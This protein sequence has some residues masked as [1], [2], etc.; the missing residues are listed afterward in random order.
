V[1][2]SKHERHGSWGKWGTS[3]LP[4]ED[5]IWGAG[6]YRADTPEETKRRV[7]PSHDEGYK[8]FAPFGFVRYADEQYPYLER[9]DFSSGIRGSG[10]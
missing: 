3:E 5:V 2:V 4:G 10:R 8:W 1:G 9:P 6:L 7:E